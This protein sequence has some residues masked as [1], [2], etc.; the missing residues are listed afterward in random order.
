VVTQHRA[1]LTF[2]QQLAILGACLS[3]DD[4]FEW[5]ITNRPGDDA[6]V[7]GALGALGD[8]R[9]L[10]W[11]E[12]VTDLVPKPEWSSAA[13]AAGLDWARTSAW[14]ARGRPLS[15]VALDALALPK[16]TSQR[17]APLPIAHRAELRRLLDFAAASDPS[18]RVRK[19]VADARTVY[20]LKG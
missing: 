10:D 8:P 18:P 3:D 12:R 4:A 6:S 11:L 20:G 13:H 14:I 19:A 5:A 2:G 1:R 17:V 16:R 15:L 9:L 7:I